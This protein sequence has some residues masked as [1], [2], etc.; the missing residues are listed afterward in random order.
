MLSVVW[1]NTE[2]EVATTLLQLHQTMLCF[3]SR[4]VGVEHKRGK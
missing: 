2:W 3:H 4:L 1:G